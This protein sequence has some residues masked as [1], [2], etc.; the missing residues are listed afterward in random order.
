[1]KK[2]ITV[3]LAIIAMV[4]AFV[5][6]AFALE[7][8]YIPM[9]VSFQAVS[10]AAASETVAPFAFIAPE[11][12]TVKSV[13]VTEA[14]GV[15]AN[16]T[17]TATFTLKDDGSAIQSFRTTAALTAMTPKAFTLVTAAG[18]NRIAKGSI[19]TVAITKQAS[20]VALTTPVV[21]LNY[22]IGW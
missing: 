18:A 12:I 8:D 1:M 22:T 7:A 11:N 2:N 16:A 9:S 5:A 15:T 14:D 20:G 17:D 4:V 19:V 6:P 21:Q 10:L 3:I 13:Y